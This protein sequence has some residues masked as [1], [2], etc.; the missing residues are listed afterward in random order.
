VPRIPFFFILA[1]GIEYTR[2][3]CIDLSRDIAVTDSDARCSF[4]RSQGFARGKDRVSQ[5]PRDIEFTRIS[6]R[7]NIE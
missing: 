2:S 6:I 7:F 5:I 1:G 4:L 3:K